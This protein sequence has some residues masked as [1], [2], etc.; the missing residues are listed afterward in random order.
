MRLTK[1]LKVFNAVF[2]EKK[3]WVAYSNYAAS[4]GALGYS[5]PYHPDIIRE[6]SYRRH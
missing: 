3:V 1:V 6:N 2:Q 5:R 4:D